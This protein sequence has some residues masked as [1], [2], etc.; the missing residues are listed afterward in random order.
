MKRTATT[1]LALCLAVLGSVLFAGPA[2]AH[3]VAVGATVV[4]GDAPGTWDV[5]WTVR[6]WKDPVAS[7]TATVSAASR[8]VVPVGT[9]FAADQARS[10]TETVSATTP[11]TLTVSLRWANG[12]TGSATASASS[13]PACA[14]VLVDVV[15][16]APSVTPATCLS[17][18]TLVVPAD[19][20]KVRYTQ[21]PAGSG[22]GTYVVTATAAPGHQLVG[23]STWRLT[24]PDRS[25]V[26]DCLVQVRPVA[27]KVN[28]AVDC[29]TPGSLTM[30]RTEGVRYVL[31][32]GNGTTGAWEVT[33]FAKPG[34]AIANGARTV[35]TGNLG[36]PEACEPLPGAPGTPG[37]PGVNVPGKP[38][39]S[40]PPVATGTPTPGTPGTP[41]SSTPGLPATGADANLV[42]LSATGLGLLALGAAMI[43]VTRRRS[44]RRG[45]AG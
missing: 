36:R 32:R 13:F 20:D 9:T 2:S 28:A 21:S 35:F 4:C 3:H 14:P 31:T 38:P 12:S 11:L 19:T 45:L 1:A 37:T 6:N 27:P 15:P 10:F 40:K 43:V 16:A 17:D 42:A 34:Y 33:A 8:K 30:A 23:T 24:V 7:N 29:D 41:V 5:T 39:V 26:L 18:G 44:T 25:S 22:P